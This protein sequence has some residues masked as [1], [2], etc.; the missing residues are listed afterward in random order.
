MRKA[1]VLA[2]IVLSILLTGCVEDWNGV[3]PRSA[4][5][6]IGLQANGI[7]ADGPDTVSS[8]TQLP[9]GNRVG[10]IPPFGTRGHANAYEFGTGYRV[11]AGDRLSIRVAGEA[12]LSGEFPVDASGAIS[13]PYVQSATVA[14]MTTPQIEQMIAGRLRQGYLRDPQVSVQA[15]SLRPFF[16]MGEVNTAGSY[17]Y[18]PGLTAQ[19]AIAVAAG[20]GPRA[21][22]S[23]VLLTRRDAR[24][25]ITKLV[26]LATQVF[27][28]D[29]IYVRERWF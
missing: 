11:G 26:P 25:T 7:V 24:G 13:L 22:K 12:D 21:D 2:L 14:G 23:Q 5:G 27:P 15:I 17:A 4:P 28:G 19:Q 10:P 3:G 9:M 29:I 8:I 18:Q 6:G 20:F 1:P 16:I